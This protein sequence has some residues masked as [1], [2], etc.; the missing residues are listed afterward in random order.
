MTGNEL[1]ERDMRLM[2]KYGFGMHGD[3][4]SEATVFGYRTFMSMMYNRLKM[5]DE[6]P[7]NDTPDNTPK[8]KSNVPAWP[9][10][11]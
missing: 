4:L 1:T 7:V 8:F 6:K 9:Y 11:V 5:D 3:P 10:A 2:K